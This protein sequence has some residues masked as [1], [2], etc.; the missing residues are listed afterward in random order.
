MCAVL[1]AGVPGNCSGYD[2]GG[3]LRPDTPSLLDQEV[4]AATLC[5]ILCCR[6][7]RPNPDCSL[8]LAQR[9][10]RHRRGPGKILLQSVQ[11]YCS[12]TEHCDAKAM[13][14]I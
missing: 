11:C 9:G 10:V 8:D 14:L 12:S 4:A 13:G 6:R 1:A 2:A 3:V 5:Y 7:I